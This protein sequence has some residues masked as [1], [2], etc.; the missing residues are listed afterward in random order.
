M[1]LCRAQRTIWHEAFEEMQWLGTADLDGVEPFG[2]ADGISQPQI[3]WERQRDTTSPQIDYSNI[4]ALGEFLLGYPNEY[5]KYTDRPLL[6]P[7][8]GERRICSPRKMS[9]QKRPRPQRNLSCHPHAAAGRARLLAVC[10]RA[11][12]R[13]CAEAEKLAAAFVGRTR[14][15][16]PLVPI[17]EQPIP[18][19][20]STTGTGSSESIHLRRRSDRRRL[21]FRRARSSRESTQHRLS[22]APDRSRETDHHARL[23]SERFSR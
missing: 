9:G 17:Q 16:D 14:A 6:D 7:D 4:V 15:G 11:V 19:I 20:G 22:R 2:F 10:H 1:P 5:E 3:D 12:R 13:K 23:W 21:P 18:G 8:S